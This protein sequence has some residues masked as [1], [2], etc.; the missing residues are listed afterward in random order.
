[1]LQD[2]FI[3]RLLLIVVFGVVY[4]YTML[5]MASCNSVETAP[6]K[7]IILKIIGGINILTSSLRTP[8]ILVKEFC[9]FLMPI[10]QHGLCIDILVQR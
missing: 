6:Q 2:E 9:Y 3:N 8:K 4:I 5:K 7:H 10:H 1:M